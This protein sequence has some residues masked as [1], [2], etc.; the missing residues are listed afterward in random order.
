M[1]STSRVSWVTSIL[2]LNVADDPS[3]W[4][5]MGFTVIDDH[6]RFGADWPTIHLTGSQANARGIMSWTL[7]DEGSATQYS[8]KDVDGLVTRWQPTAAAS[9]SVSPNH[10]NGITAIDHLVVMTPDVDRTV[11]VFESRGWECR[12]RREGAAY[13]Q[14]QMRQ[15]F[16]WLGEVIVEVVGPETAD[17]AKAHEPAAF[18]GLALTSSDLAVTQQFFG[19][20]MKPPVDAVQAGRQITTISSRAGS[21]L[22]IAVMSPHI[23]TDD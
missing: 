23:K 22:A 7:I 13:G 2:T 20:L 4:T 14:Q 16:F 8:A 6:V 11:K 17:E 1:S 9:A 15:A 12:R 5:A 21:T 19:D 18:F 3:T 10:E